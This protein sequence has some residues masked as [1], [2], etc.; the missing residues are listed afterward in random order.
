M[1]K[2]KVEHILGKGSVL[3]LR[4]TVRETIIQ[5]SPPQTIPEVWNTSSGWAQLSKCPLLPLN[6]LSEDKDKSGPYKDSP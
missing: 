3:V 5:L 2:T 6:L 1:F 4:Q